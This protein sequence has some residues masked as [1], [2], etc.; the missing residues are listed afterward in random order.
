MKLDIV[1]G[2]VMIAFT[3]PSFSR[4]LLVLPPFI[5]P[6]VTPITTYL[7]VCVCVNL[8]NFLRATP[9]ASNLYLFL[10]SSDS[11]ESQ[12]LSIHV[13]YSMSIM[14]MNS[15]SFNVIERL[16]GQVNSFAVQY[17]RFHTLKCCTA[18]HFC[19]GT[20]HSRYVDRIEATQLDWSGHSMIAFRGS[21]I[22][23]GL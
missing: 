21:Q 9:Y 20:I 22:S 8:H 18:W 11:C 2:Q 6:R 10:C 19:V 12:V 13:C 1:L 5:F 16:T 23:V 4:A 17:S 14:I 7:S 3:L 15:P